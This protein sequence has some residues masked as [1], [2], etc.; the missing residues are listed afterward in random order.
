M[1][2]REDVIFGLTEELHND[3]AT[4][5]EAVVDQEDKVAFGLIDE[6]RRKLKMLKDN[7]IKKE[8]V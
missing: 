4:I 6:L 3:V 5:Y 1:I 7:L 2:R 8:G